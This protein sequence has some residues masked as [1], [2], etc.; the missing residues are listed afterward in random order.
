MDV[1]TRLR[2]VLR[3]G[4]WWRCWMVLKR[5]ISLI[6]T[7]LNVEQIQ[8]VF[9]PTNN[10]FV[11]LNLESWV[12]VHGIFWIHIYVDWVRSSI[13]IIGCV[14]V[15][16]QLLRLQLLVDLRNTVG[17]RV[18]VD[19]FF[20][21][22]QL[23][24]HLLFLAEIFT[25]LLDERGLGGS[26][27]SVD[28]NLLDVDNFWAIHVIAF[29]VKLSLPSLNGVHGWKF[30]LQTDKIVRDIVFVW[31]CWSHG[32]RLP[33]HG[34]VRADSWLL[35]SRM[36]GSTYQRSSRFNQDLIWITVLFF[37]LLF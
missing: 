10:I 2:I 33:W 11:A 6:Q 31:W 19:L 27:E 4:I 32:F 3:L 26:L 1:L 20:V 16:E 34:V 29:E 24:S 28:G 7:H 8:R 17:G 35:F 13:R 23:F 37:L 21:P 14:L 15:F 12:G 36:M 9:R 18:V 22:F 5:L 25:D 30:R